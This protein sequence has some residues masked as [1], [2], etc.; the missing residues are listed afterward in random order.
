MT[1]LIKVTSDYWGDAESVRYTKFTREKMEEAIEVYTEDTYDTEGYED[2]LNGV[3]GAERY[4]ERE[5]R[6]WDSPSGY[7][8]EVIDYDEEVTRLN[9]KLTKELDRLGKAMVDLT[10]D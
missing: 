6:D 7:S 2:L 9:D 5:D 8:I 4:E 10:N 3:V 1:K